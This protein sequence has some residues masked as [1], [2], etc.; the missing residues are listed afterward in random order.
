MRVRLRLEQLEDRLTPSTTWTVNITTDNGGLVGQQTGQNTGD[1]RY[2]ASNAEAGD[3]IV[4]AQGLAGQ[5]INLNAQIDLDEGVDINGNNA[6]GQSQNITISGQNQTRIFVVESGELDT[7]NGLT[8]TGGNGGNGGAIL[9]VWGSSLTLNNDNFNN[10]KV[11]AANSN[12]DAIENDGTTTINGGTFQNNSAANKG[13][14]IENTNNLLVYPTQGSGAAVNFVSRLCLVSTNL[15]RL[16]L[17]NALPQSGKIEKMGTYLA[18]P[19]CHF[20]PMR[21]KAGQRQCRLI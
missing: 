21:C 18:S 7:I 4:F 15:G 13:G 14:A 12:G 11:T 16:E 20:L 3:T 1:L 10:T 17:C 5:T 6:N 8:F 9:V 2:C 19:V